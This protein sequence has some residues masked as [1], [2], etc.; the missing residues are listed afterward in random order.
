MKLLCP[1]QMNPTLN[2]AQL[3]VSLKVGAVTIQYF[4]V[5]ENINAALSYQKRI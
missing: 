4:C 5:Q 2:L 3:K 1:E